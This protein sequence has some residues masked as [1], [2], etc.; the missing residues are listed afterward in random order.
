[1]EK[2]PLSGKFSASEFEG[3]LE[4]LKETPDTEE[5]TEEISHF[6]TDR[7]YGA[8]P[9]VIH[10]LVIDMARLQWHEFKQKL[11]NIALEN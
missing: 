2:M 10:D 5:R 4:K 1:M 11:E 9:K 8:D 3:L 7:G 6:L